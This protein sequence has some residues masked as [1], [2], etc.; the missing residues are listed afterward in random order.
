MGKRM[1]LGGRR[2]SR[3][4]A[5]FLWC[6]RQHALF[7]GSNNERV[8]AP[9]V[10]AHSTQSHIITEWF[11]FWKN[12]CDYYLHLLALTVFSFSWELVVLCK[13][14]TLWQQRTETAKEHKPY[15]CRKR[16]KTSQALHI[17]YLLIK[18]L[19][20]FS[21]LSNIHWTLVSNKQARQQH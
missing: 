12:T 1:C 8:T 5:F 9:S 21:F 10:Y 13:K 2:Y 17:F 4:T 7:F 14:Q 3:S 16:Y 11:L 6:V 20:W 15:N 19:T 18:V